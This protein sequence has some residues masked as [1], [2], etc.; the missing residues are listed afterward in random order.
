MRALVVPAAAVL[1]AV[2]AVVACTTQ[3]PP[4]QSDSASP[5]AVASREFPTQFAPTAEPS[6]ALTTFS[7]DVENRSAVGVV[8]SVE[9]DFGGAMPGFL[10]GERGTIV[11][12]L[13]N[14]RNGISV[15][16]QGGQCGLLAS[17]EYPTPDPFTLLIED[18]SRSGQIRLSTRGGAL[19][20][21]IPLPSNSLRG[22]SG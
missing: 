2:L 6:V 20:T 15:E 14:P 13:L 1:S 17:A 4:S 9:S 5:S 16:I 7:F 19:S 10:P 21:A 3:V 8:V 18:G 22:C 11:I 12:R